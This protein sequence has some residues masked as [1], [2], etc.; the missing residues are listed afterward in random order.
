MYKKR[1]LIGKEAVIKTLDIRIY[2]ITLV[3]L[4][5]DFDQESSFGCIKRRDCVTKASVSVLSA[6]V[7]SSVV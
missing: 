4:I 1:L 2:L 6:F 3:V 7:G 5:S